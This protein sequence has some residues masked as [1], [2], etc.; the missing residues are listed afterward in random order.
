MKYPVSE[1]DIRQ[2][3]NKVTFA[4]GW[5]FQPPTEYKKVEATTQP[6]GTVEGDPVRVENNWYQTWVP[7]PVEPEATPEVPVEEKK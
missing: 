6:D 3:Y 7:A 1:F 5:D 2:E 4:S